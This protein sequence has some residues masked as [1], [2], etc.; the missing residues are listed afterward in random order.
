MGLFNKLFGSNTASASE[1]ADRAAIAD[2]TE[3][4][5][6]DTNHAAAYTN[7]GNCHL[8]QADYDQAIKDYTQAIRCQRKMPPAFLAMAYTNRGAAHSCKQEYDKA[9]VDH[10]EAASTPTSPAPT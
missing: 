8:V 2:F 5:R 3:A 6:L 7:R 10:T 9:I 4:I 1:H